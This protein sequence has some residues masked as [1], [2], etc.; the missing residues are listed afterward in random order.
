MRKVYRFIN[1][2]LVLT[3]SVCLTGCLENNNA[4]SA[5]FRFVKPTSGRTFLFAN[6]TADSILMQSYGP[7][8]ITSDTYGVDWCVFSQTRG[9]AAGIYSLLVRFSQN[10]SNSSRLAQFTVTDLNHPDEAH[11]T[12]QYLQHATRGDGSLGS[13]AL[14]KGITSSDGWELTFSY[15]TNNR[16]VQLRMKDPDGNNDDYR[17]DYN[18]TTWRL[19]VT[20]SNGTM[21]GTMDNGY[22]TEQLI[23]GG[24]TIGYSVQY[25]PNG[26]Q[27]PISDAFN[28]QASRQRRT[29][30][31][32]YL[33]GGKS[34]SPDSLHT[35]DSLK[36][37]CRW[38]AEAKPTIFERY[39]LAYGTMDNRYQNVDV[40]QLILGMTHCEP[41]QL[42]SMFRYTRSTSIVT[43]AIAADGVIDVSTELNAN[44]S[45]HRMVVKDAC[46]GT[47]TTYDFQY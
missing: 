6:T 31:F 9:N 47:E 27:M 40:N 37:Y 29:Q 22:Q 30:I 7:W 44:R 8:Q 38:K 5:G 2:L 15:D 20:T 17:M 19:T 35:A 13:A 39:K 24:D 45:V 16:P 12:W 4:Y 46:H 21:S 10:T 34:L 41:L 3:A 23:G 14:V 32:A 43:K 28:Y 25:Y 33:I 1:I 18:E 36:Y 42:L 26:V 11:A